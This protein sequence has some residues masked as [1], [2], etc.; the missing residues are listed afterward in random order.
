MRN[1]LDVVNFWACM[2]KFVGEAANICVTVRRRAA[3]IPGDDVSAQSGQ[4]DERSR[5]KKSAGIFKEAFRV[6]L[7]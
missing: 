6:N 5:H 2:A 4:P 3:S 7:F 1:T